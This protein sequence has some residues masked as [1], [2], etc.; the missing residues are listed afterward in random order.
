GPGNYV[1]AGKDGTSGG[2]YTGTAT[3]TQ[4][5]DS[6]WRIVWRIGGQVWNGFGIGDGKIVALNFS[7][8]GRTGVMLLVAKDDDSGYQAAWAY[9]GDRTVGLE[10]WSRQ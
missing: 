3:L 4:T 8:H 6:T 7:G 5:S 10:D 1:V 2:G 9:T